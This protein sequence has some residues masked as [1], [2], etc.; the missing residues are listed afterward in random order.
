MKKLI[1]SL[2]FVA[3]FAAAALPCRAQPAPKILVMDLEK[4]FNSHYKTQEQQAKLQSDKLKAQESLDAI[5][6]EGTALVEQYKELD[7]AAKNP[8][9]TPD[10][11][12]QKQGLAQK[13]VDEIRAKQTERDAFVQNTTNTLQQRFQTFKSLI[14]EEINHVAIDVAKR[15]GATLLIDKSGPTMI[16]VSSIIYFDPSL[17]ITDEVVADINKDRPPTSVVPASATAPT[18]T[19]AP[20]TGAPQITV[21][22]IK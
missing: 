11:K 22:G 1:W 8:A 16:G 13:K 14:I 5:T 19:T 7:E 21:P 9:L 10:A 2:S 15:K 20:S 4:I 3:C 17:D 6:K 18:T 12:S